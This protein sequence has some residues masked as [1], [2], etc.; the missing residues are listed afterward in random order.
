M[1][2][3]LNKREVVNAILNT[4]RKTGSSVFSASNGSTGVTLLPYLTD[5]HSKL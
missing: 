2:T 4:Q 1:N 3:F 5:H